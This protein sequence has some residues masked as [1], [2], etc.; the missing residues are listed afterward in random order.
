MKKN[1]TTEYADILFEITRNQEALDVEKIIHVYTKFLKKR[2][3]LGKIDEILKKYNSIASGQRK[4]VY[5]TLL[6]AE[7]MEE[8]EEKEIIK[9]LKNEIGATDV[10]VENKIDK[11]LI[12]GWKIKT[13]EFLIDASL[14]SRLNKMKRTLVK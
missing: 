6:S 9:I 13:D 8:K 1:S 11:S 4:I 3:M 2:K 7:K 10:E 14:R 12:A 5:A